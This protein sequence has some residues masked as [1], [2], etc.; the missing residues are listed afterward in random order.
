V[1]VQLL[2]PQRAEAWFG[3]LDEL[4]GP[5]PF[6]GAQVDL[7]LMCYGA[8]GQ[9]KQ[10]DV[11]L[12][13]L[14][15]RFSF[16]PEERDTDR[17]FSF[18]LGTRL[19]FTVDRPSATDADP[20]AFA[21]GHPI[22][23]LTVVPSVSYRP[24]YQLVRNLDKDDWRRKLDWVDIGAGYGAYRFIS[25]GFDDFSG[26]EAEFRADFH[27]P[28]ALME[29]LKR[30]NKHWRLLPQVRYTK[31]GFLDGFAANAFNPV[32]QDPT[33]KLPSAI[34]AAND[35]S[36]AIKG[37]DWVGSWTFFIETRFGK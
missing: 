33:A 35:K 5:G 20:R 31:V 4:S 11:D 21:D 37:P 19:F 13:A 23:L 28:A 29:K 6:W 3:W 18:D 14:G 16:C 24:I 8:R 34:P 26:D 36:R 9:Q 10:Q 25:K 7:R 1:F 32:L 17:L 27:V 12:M 15:V 2:L 30:R 22:F